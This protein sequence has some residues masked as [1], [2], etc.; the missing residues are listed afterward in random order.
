M[1]QCQVVP[2][3]MPSWVHVIL[4]KNDLVKEVGSLAVAQSLCISMTWI[5]V[6]C[7]IEAQTLVP[8][9][10]Y[11]ARSETDGV[12]SEFKITKP[13]IYMSFWLHL[14]QQSPGVSLFRFT[15]RTWLMACS[16]CMLH[17]KWKK[18]WPT[19]MSR[20]HPVF[21]LSQ[22][23]SCRNVMLLFLTSFNFFN[24]DEAI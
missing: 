7:W 20:E 2:T 23:S 8:N 10:D 5:Y 6:C 13:R 3:C 16:T 17:G 11:T 18:Q 19:T 14:N 24:L 22:Q 15:P 12:P 4:W 9:S 21:K 1:S